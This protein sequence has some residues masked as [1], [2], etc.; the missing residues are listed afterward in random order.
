MRVARLVAAALVAAVVFSGPATAQDARRGA[1]LAAHAC[2]NCHGSDGRSQERDIPSLAG[3]QAEFI[4]LQLILFREGI[5][6]VDAMNAFTAGMPDK[7]IED[8]AAYFASLPPG[9]PDDRRPRN[10]DLFAAGQAAAG[11][12]HCAVC[13]LPDYRGRNQVPRVAGQREEFLVS[14]LTAYRDGRRAGADTQMN[15]AVARISDADI[16]ALAH[17]LSQLD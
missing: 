10:P 4:T 13:H 11:P 8:L 7:D 5:R 2:V 17:F 9:P 12:R 14:A 3:Q 16:T 6:R 1:A 15:G